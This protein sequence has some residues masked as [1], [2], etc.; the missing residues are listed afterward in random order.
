MKLFFSL[1]AQCSLTENSLSGPL[2]QL[3]NQWPELTGNNGKLGA[4]HSPTQSFNHGQETVK[5]TCA[6]RGNNARFA[7]ETKETG[8]SGIVH[9]WVGEEACSVSAERQVSPSFGRL[10]PNNDKILP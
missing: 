1:S 2:S 7:S 10:L 6:M 5:V 8:L 9:D 3:R 4:I